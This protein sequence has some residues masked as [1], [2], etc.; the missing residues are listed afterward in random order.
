MLLDLVV[1]PTTKE[2]VLAVG[3]LVDHQ[4]GLVSKKGRGDPRL[5]V[6][7]ATNYCTLY[8]MWDPKIPG[9][10]GRGKHARRQASSEHKLFY[11]TPSTPIFHP[12]ICLP[13]ARACC[14]PFSFTPSPPLEVD[15]PPTKIHATHRVGAPLLGWGGVVAARKDILGS[16]RRAERGRETNT[17]EGEERHGAL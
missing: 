15:V 3:S 5:G 8:S 4:V 11:S 16:S 10:Q 14:Q 2:H 17:C 7:S 1:P 12:G 13:R 9:A 6:G